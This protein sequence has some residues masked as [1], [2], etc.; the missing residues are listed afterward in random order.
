[1]DKSSLF[2]TLKLGLTA[3][4]AAGGS[5][6]SAAA[7]ESTGGLL[8]GKG[9][10]SLGT[11]SAPVHVTQA[12]PSFRAQMWRSIR[13]LGLAFIVISGIGALMEDKGGMPSRFLSGYY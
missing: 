11:P 3:Q 10:G 13:S 4:S 9:P 7:A 5:Q 6:G 12:E 2:R 8:S 1:M